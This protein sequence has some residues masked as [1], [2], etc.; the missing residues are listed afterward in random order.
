ME[1][2]KVNERMVH[3]LGKKNFGRKTIENMESLSNIDQVMDFEQYRSNI[4]FFKFFHCFF[5][6]S[7]YL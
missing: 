4:Y 5:N 7:N 6:I 1:L 2:E 3:N